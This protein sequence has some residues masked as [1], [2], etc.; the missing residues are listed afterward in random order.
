[1][2]TTIP[3]SKPPRFCSFQA[4]RTFGL[5]PPTRSRFASSTLSIGS[6]SS[7]GGNP[8]GQPGVRSHAIAC[9][10]DPRTSGAFGFAPRLSRSAAVSK[11]PLIVAS[12]NAEVPSFVLSFGSARWSSKRPTMSRCPLRAAN[13]NDVKP[14]VDR[15]ETLAPLSSSTR[16]TAAWPSTAAHISA[17]CPRHASRVLTSAPR[18]SSAWTAGSTPARDAA[19]SGVSPSGFARFGSAPLSSSRW[20]MSEKPLALA[21]ASGVTP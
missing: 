15:A 7:S 8:S 21:M 14:A 16:T 2:F 12:I 11:R 5:A 18:A 4:I 13:N 1:L 17:V 10:A 9:S 6:W 3:R 19:I 20:T